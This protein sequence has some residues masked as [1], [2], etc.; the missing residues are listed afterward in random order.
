MSFQVVIPARHASTRLVRKM[1][2]D[3]GGKPMVVRV[4][5]RAARSAAA[6]VIVAT[7]HAEIEMAVRSHG[8]RVLMTKVEH[9]SGTDR[10]AEVADKLGLD[11]DAVFVNV[12]GD[13]PLIDPAL[14]DAVAAELYAH[15]DAAIATAAKPM[16]AAVDFFNPNYVKVVCDVTGLALYFSRAPIP[17]AR[18]AF[19][20]TKNILPA[21]L[22]ALHH[23][24]IYAYRVAFLKRFGTLP[25]CPA[26]RFEALEQLR[27]LHHGY[28][29][30]VKVWPGTVEAGVD[31]AADLK[32]V[33]ERW[34]D[35]NRG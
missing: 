33:R 24:G 21:G 1:L 29:I 26:E 20:G 22:P 13:E 3:I 31:T 32:R 4:A 5:E 23:I 2:L 18:D 9:N 25:Q 8:V 7:D 16:A 17:F 12:Q 28:R 14:I 6:E 34:H 30:A 15:P 35:L 11:D 19:A 27:A 10:L